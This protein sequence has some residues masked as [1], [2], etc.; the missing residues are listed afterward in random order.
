VSFEQSTRTFPSRVVSQTV[1]AG[2]T[3]FLRCSTPSVQIWPQSSR[4]PNLVVDGAAAA[5][6]DEAEVH[7]RRLRLHHERLRR[8]VAVVE[9]A[10]HRVGVD[11]DEVAGLPV[12]ALVVVD[13]VAL[14]LQDVEDRLVLVAV[15]V[16]R[17]ARRD[18]D[19]VDLD[20]LRQERIVAGADAPPG[21]RVLRVA[22][23]ADLRIV[24]DDLVVAD[25]RRRQ[26]RLPKFL[27]PVLLGTHTPQEDAAFLRHL[28]AP[29]LD[30]RPRLT[31][32]SY[33]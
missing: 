1:S 7:P 24:D 31:Q 27:E 20:V 30:A 17:L 32:M 33:H 2:L 18:L 4:G 10:V 25:A 6:L 28:T 14:A 8:L 11:D 21:A 19:E 23:V 15:A 12:V 13:L 26:L 29:F 5:L 22:G 9:V 16:V 3:T